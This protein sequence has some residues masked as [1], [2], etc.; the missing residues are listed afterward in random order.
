MM[1]NRLASTLVVCI[2]NAIASDDGVGEAVYEVLARHTL[3]PTVKLELLGVAGLDLVEL[4][5]GENQLIIVDAVRLGG[6]VGSVKVLDYHTLDVV[7][8]RGNSIHDIGVHEALQLVETLYPDRLP[9]SITIVGVEG[10][11][12]N[13]VGGLS[14]SVM[15]AV[16]PCAETV[17]ALLPK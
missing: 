7:K 6:E 1:E 10:E 11:T 13:K 16:T 17:L 2:G 14:P 4:I 12:F 9:E 8:G 3:S 15:K 5:N